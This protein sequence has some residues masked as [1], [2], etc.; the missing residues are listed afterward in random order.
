M[1]ALI[2][3]AAVV[4]A[5]VAFHYANS[6]ATDDG[7]SLDDDLEELGALEKDDQGYIKFEYFLK[8]FQICSFYGKNQFA[9]DKKQFIADRRAALKNNDDKKYEEIVMEMTQR[10][11][12]LV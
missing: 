12:L 7:P 1:Y 11:E 10:E 6:K 2:G 9:R 3:G 5:A 8:I 4:G